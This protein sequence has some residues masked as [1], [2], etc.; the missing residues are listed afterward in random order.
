MIDYHSFGE[1]IL[2]PEGWQVE[3]PGHRRSALYTLAGRNEANTAI[4]GYDPDLSAELYTTNGDITDDALTT[5]SALAYTVELTGGSGRRSAART[6]RIRPTRRTASPSRTPTPTSRP[7]SRRT[8]ASR[9]TSPGRPRIRTTRSRTS[10]TPRRL[11]AERVHASYGDPQLVE[12]NAKRTLGHDAGPTGRSSRRADAAAAAR[13]VAGRPAP[14]RARR[15]L[16]PPAR[17]RITTGAQPGQTCACGSPARR[18]D[19]APFPYTL[20]S[21]HRRP[22]AD[23]GRGG[24]H[25]PARAS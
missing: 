2:Y 16:P 15:L 21:R 11:R 9:S 20:V 4:P 1:L 13:R 18:P 5:S 19:L 6:A 8:S 12:V 24:L 7:C 17:R 22:R 23:H 14:R 10:A 3:T 25:G